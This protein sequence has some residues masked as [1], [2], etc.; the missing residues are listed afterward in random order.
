M[1]LSQSLEGKKVKIM[2]IS[3]EIFEGV[4]LD[5]I[6]PE[7]NEPDGISAIDI[8]KCPQRGGRGVSFNETDIKSIEVLS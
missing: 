5:Y 6:Y 8:E 3:G 1:K 4:V 2:D 7:D